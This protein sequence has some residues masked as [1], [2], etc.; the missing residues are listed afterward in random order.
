VNAGFL[1]VQPDSSNN[2]IAFIKSDNNNMT[3]ANNGTSRVSGT[4]SVPIAEWAGS[5]TVNLAQNDVEYAYSTNTVTT[6]GNTQSDDGLYGYGPSGSQFVAIDSTTLSSLTKKRVRFQTP[7]Q[8]GDVIELEFFA[9]NGWFS[10]SQFGTLAANLRVD[11]TALIGASCEAIVGSSTDIYVLFGNAGRTA[12]T[13]GASGNTWAGIAGSNTYKW[14]VRKSSAGAAVGF[15][16]A[17]SV[18]TGLVAP[19]KGQYSLT[20]TGTNW[21]TVRAVGIYYQEQ[22]G[23]PRFKFNIIGTLS[24]TATDFTGT[25]SG[26]TFKSGSSLFQA[27]TAHM[28]QDGTAIRSIIGSYVTPSSSTFYVGA[29]GATNRICVSGDVELESIPSWA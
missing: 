6:A 20:V 9:D 23:V 13:Y 15:G 16:K 8:T 10:A 1:T 25:I 3:W 28:Q 26:V 12:G 4:F 5:G 29:S 14:R 2:T 19:R 22:D 17:T 27:I 24:S 21:T 11:N 7:I 18:S